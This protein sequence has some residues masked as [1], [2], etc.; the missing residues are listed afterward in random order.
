M[1]DFKKGSRELETEIKKDLCYIDSLFFMKYL[2]LTKNS[3]T[4]I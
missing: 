1:I 4:R 3:M 2:C